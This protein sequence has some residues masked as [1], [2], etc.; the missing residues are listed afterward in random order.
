MV[1]AVANL[2]RSGLYDWL[3]QR[4]SGLALLAWFIALA[5]IL[6]ANPGLDYPTWRAALAALPMRVL[7]TAAMLSLAA[8]AWIGLWCVLTD[9]ITPRMLGPR[10]DLLR[11]LL[12]ALCGIALF[13][14]AVWGLRIVWS[15]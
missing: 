12:S 1:T 3:A 9:Y 15:A 7:G 8:H 14:Y 6:L 2:G 4:L 5:G 13:S 11:G 10:A